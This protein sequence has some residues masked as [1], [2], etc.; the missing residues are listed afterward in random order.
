MFDDGQT[1]MNRTIAVLGDNRLEGEDASQ[2]CS[3]L[4]GTSVAD[5]L[6]PEK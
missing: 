6:P 5:G 4:P 2:H 3:C 1:P